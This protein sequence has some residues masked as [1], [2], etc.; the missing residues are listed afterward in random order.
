ML[1]VCPSCGTSY[2]VKSAH[3]PAGGTP[4]PLRAL[5]HGLARRTKPRR[6][7]PCRCSGASVRIPDCRRRGVW[8]WPS[9][10]CQGSAAADGQELRAA[11]RSVRVSAGWRERPRRFFRRAERRRGGASAA[12]RTRRFR[13]RAVLRSMSTP[14]SAP[15]LPE[16]IETVAARR[17]GR[18]AATATQRLAAVAPAHRDPRAGADRRYPH[19]LARRR[20]ARLAANCPVLRSARHAGE[21]ARAYFRQRRHDDR[22]A[23][24]RADPRGRRKYRQRTRAKSSTC[25][26]LKFFVRNAARQEIYSWTAVPSRAT[27]P[28]GEAVAFRSRLASPPPDAHDLIVRFVTRPTSSPERVSHG[29]NSDRRGR[30]S[31]ARHCVRARSSTDGHEVKTACDGSD[32]LDVLERERGVSISCSPTFACRSWTASRSRSASPAI[33]PTSR[34]S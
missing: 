12:D 24:G 18:A 21:F 19:R 3:M 29:A 26:G 1:I 22:A 34:F 15:T 23:R 11:A 9:R 33:I 2:D 31:F 8:V 27:L 10:S 28:P 7:S 13:G 5:P 14:A 25:R 32:A 30:G 16:D 20:R 6:Q 4:G 17:Q